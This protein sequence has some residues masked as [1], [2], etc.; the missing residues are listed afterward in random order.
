MEKRKKIE[1]KPTTYRGIRYRSKLEARWAVF[2]DYY[3]LM[4]ESYYEPRSFHIESFNWVYTPDFYFSWAGY[5]SYLE[6]KP[7]QPSDE[8]IDG[9]QLI[10]DCA[11]EI[12]LLLGI[13]NFYK[14]EPQIVVVEPDELKEPVS[15]AEYWPGCEQA[16]KTASGYRF[17]LGGKDPL[18][19]F[20]AGRGKQPAM[21]WQE[22]Q[23]EERAQLIEERRKEL[24]KRMKK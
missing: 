13:G 7:G 2:L 20:R 15:L 24:R 3:H 21:Y 22:S 12:P 5:P 14:G 11:I 23:A 9:L 8:Y 1:A 16:V 18:P 4:T 17:D 19:P 10:V 6:I